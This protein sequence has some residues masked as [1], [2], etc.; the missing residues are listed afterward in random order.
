VFFLPFLLG[1]DEQKIK[2]NEHQDDRDKSTK[3]SC[4]FSAGAST[5]HCIS[6]VNQ[7]NTSYN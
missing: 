2:N 1:P 3:P 7:D 4:A 6:D 5:T